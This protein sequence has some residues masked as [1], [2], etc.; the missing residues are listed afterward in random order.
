M[1]PFPSGCKLRFL[2]A[3]VGIEIGRLCIH[4]F[5]AHS[6]DVPNEAQLAKHIRTI[7]L[8]QF[9]QTT[10]SSLILG[11]SLTIRETVPM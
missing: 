9:G 10:R 4:S 1:A 2:A 8:S 5:N 7:R 3:H 6:N 11:S